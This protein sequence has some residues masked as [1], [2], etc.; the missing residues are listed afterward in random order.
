MASP[1]DHPPA[2]TPSS[3]NRNDQPTSET[4]IDQIAAKMQQLSQRLSKQ[5]GQS[6]NTDH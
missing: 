2:V 5:G 4:K 3:S 6:S 1:N